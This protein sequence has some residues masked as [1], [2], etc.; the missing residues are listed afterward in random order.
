M[1]QEGF[2]SLSYRSK[3]SATLLWCAAPGLCPLVKAGCGHLFS[4]SWFSDVTLLARNQPWCKNLHLGNQQV[5]QIRA[6]PSQR[7]SHYTLT[8]T[9]LLTA[10]SD[11]TQ[12]RSSKVLPCHLRG[13]I[14]NVDFASN[15]K[16]YPIHGIM[17]FL[18]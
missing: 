18:K 3:L 8:S 5:L 7:T 1:C 15:H 4:T 11:L 2:P 14:F 10:N 16:S 12:F 6:F 17:P 9:S 13:T